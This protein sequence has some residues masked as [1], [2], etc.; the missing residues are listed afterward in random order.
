MFQFDDLFI[1]RFYYSVKAG[2]VAFIPE[3]DENA[4]QFL[5]F[6]ICMVGIEVFTP[7]LVELVQPAIF[8][9]AR[10][11]LKEMGDGFCFLGIVKVEGFQLFVMVEEVEEKQQLFFGEDV[12]F[13]AFGLFFGGDLFPDDGV[14]VEFVF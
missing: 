11:G 2:R 7:V 1:G 12:F 9:F 5:A 13:F 8:Y 3:V 14:D 4:D 6:A 10:D